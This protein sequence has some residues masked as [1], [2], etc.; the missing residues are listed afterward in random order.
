MNT[1]SVCRLFTRAGRDSTVETS[2]TIAGA[3]VGVMVLFVEE[4]FKHLLVVNS[5]KDTEN[6]S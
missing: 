2:T 3:A 6:R 5:P 1:F 4:N